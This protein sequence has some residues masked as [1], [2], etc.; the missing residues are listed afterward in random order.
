LNNLRWYTLGM[1][2]LA[3]VLTLS[4]WFSATAVSSELAAELGLT[5]SQRVWLINVVQAGFVIGALCVSFFA[6]AD[7]FPMKNL[8]VLGAISAGLANAAL[9]MNPTPVA[10]ILAR[11]ATGIS[12]A[13][14]YPTAM[15]FIGTWFIMGRGLAMGAVVGALT[16]G[17]AAPHLIRAFG[18]GIDWRIVIIITTLA[19]A[20]AAVIFIF[21]REGPHQFK[22]ARFEFRHVHRVL[23]NRAA[24]L[25]NLGYFGHMWE[26]YALWGWLLAYVTGAK[27]AG[28]D[29]SN[30]S[31]VTF[32]AI[33]T[34][35]FGCLVGGWM[36][37]QFGRCLTSALAMAI[38]G[39]CALL[40][41][42]FYTGPVTVFVLVALVWGFSTIADS[43]QFSAAV[44]EV[45]DPS[46]VGASLAFQMGIGFAITL[47]SIW[48]V[49]W[50]ASF[51]GDWQ[52]A[53]SILAVGPFLGCW[54]MLKLRRLPEA[55]QLAGGKR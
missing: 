40:I 42:F 25:A 4:T 44:S 6:L 55:A 10:A 8:L 22:S 37:D 5:A 13:L 36:A 17:S 41:G 26:L 9:L 29:I 48:L 32:A 23:N 53:F 20:L 39:S 14:V 12:L 34:G 30:A 2:G 49:Q 50:I 3:V 52:W 19:C 43:A 33:A 47:L 27:V 45:S 35:T 1:T 24:M 38:S 11:F 28:L 15:K 7:V 31:L 54:A 51:L 18:V 16:L 46:L 21:L